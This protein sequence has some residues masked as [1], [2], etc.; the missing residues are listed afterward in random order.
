LR[1]ALQTSNDNLVRCF[2]GTI[3]C[4]GDASRVLA[5][6]RLAQPFKRIVGLAL[7]ST[8]HFLDASPLPLHL[9]DMALHVFQLWDVPE[10]LTFY[11]PKLEN[12]DEAAYVHAL[13]AS[14]ERHIATLHPTYKAGTIR[15]LV[16]LEV[17]QNRTL[18]VERAHADVNCVVVCFM[19]RHRV[20]SFESMRS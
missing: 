11:V 14:V 18:R 17:R 13:C 7:P 16:V 19:C 8:A 3:K 2:R 1:D 9:V 6:S 4:A 20:L 10:A 5:A 12:D 15:L